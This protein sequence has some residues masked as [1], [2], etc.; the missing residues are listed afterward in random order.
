MTNNDNLVDTNSEAYRHQCEVQNVV[1]MYREKG[2]DAVKKFILLIE[3]HRGSETAQRLRNEA[4]QQV[5][6]GKTNGRAR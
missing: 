1:R 6:L 5:Q 3:K 2:G 4:L